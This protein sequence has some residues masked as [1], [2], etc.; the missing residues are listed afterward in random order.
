M[1]SAKPGEKRSV[2]DKRD[3]TENDEEDAEDEAHAKIE[4]DERTD[5]VKPKQKN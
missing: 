1:S 4:L 3:Y 5:E 2:A